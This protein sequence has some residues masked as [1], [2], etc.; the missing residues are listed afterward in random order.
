MLNAA[1]GYGLQVQGQRANRSVFQSH[2]IQEVLQG[3]DELPYGRWQPSRWSQ[4]HARYFRLPF[5]YFLLSATRDSNGLGNRG[6]GDRMQ[7]DWFGRIQY[8]DEPHVY[9]LPS[10]YEVR[11]NINSW[12]VEIDHLV[13]T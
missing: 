9:I 7:S 11:V 12:I 10:L 2:W 6:L 4:S 13:K 1:D 3:R 8:L 5:N